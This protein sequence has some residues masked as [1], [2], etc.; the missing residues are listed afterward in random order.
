MDRPQLRLVKT[1]QRVPKRRVVLELTGE[2]HDALL[3]YTMLLLRC[4]DEE[5][6]ADAGLTQA[7]TRLKCALEGDY[8]LVG[9]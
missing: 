7:F 6:L 4:G 3:T 8:E 1:E 9:A 2:Q 5:L